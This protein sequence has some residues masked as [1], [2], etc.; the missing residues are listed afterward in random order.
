MATAT[1]GVG[2]LGGAAKFF[3]GRSMQKKAEKFIED[4]R[5]QELENPYEDLAVS[6]LG[7]DLQ[8]EEAARTT[9]TSV[10]ALEKGGARALVGG[11]GKVQDLNNQVNKGIA[12]N[13]DEQQKAIDKMV[14][15][16]KVVNQNMIEKRQSDELAGYG[17]M[18]NTGMG[19][20]S[21]G[22]DNVINSFGAFGQSQAGQD[23]DAKIWGNS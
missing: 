10:N 14:A 11:I 22:L 13:L 17:Q 5:W 8:R 4:F 16:Q 15:G 3:S 12:A 6:T 19:M 20:K 18:M 21:Q 7:A 1:A 2:L 23:L 9:A